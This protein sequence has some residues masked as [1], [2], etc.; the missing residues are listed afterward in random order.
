M[1]SY[2]GSWEFS[3]FWRHFCLTSVGLLLPLHCLVLSLIISLTCQCYKGA[4][5]SAHFPPITLQII[6][7]N[8]N[9]RNSPFNFSLWKHG[10]FFTYLFLHAS[11]PFLRPAAKNASSCNKGK[12]VY[13]N[14]QSA[15]LLIPLG[16]TQRLAEHQ[17]INLVGWGE[18]FLMPSLLWPCQRA[19]EWCS[20]APSFLLEN[21]FASDHKKKFLTNK[22]KKNP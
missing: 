7:W 10:F 8:S 3:K 5:A 16:L 18:S 15:Q 20:A 2:Y 1:R 11:L 9:A 12:A 22:Q 19:K 6:L 17:P 4:Y 21:K 14:F 13:L